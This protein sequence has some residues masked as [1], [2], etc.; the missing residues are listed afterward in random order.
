MEVVINMVALKPQEDPQ[1]C[2]ERVHYLPTWL[3]RGAR[4]Q[5]EGSDTNK[6][7]QD[8]PRMAVMVAEHCDC[9]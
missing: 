2:P 8:S 7:E 3:G 1:A 6:K 5:E 9:T 4:L